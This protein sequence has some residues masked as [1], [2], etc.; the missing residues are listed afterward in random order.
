MHNFKELNI[1]E[2][3]LQPAN[4]V[5]KLHKKFPAG[6]RFGPVSRINRCPISIPSNIAEVSFIKSFED[7]FRFLE[8]APGSGFEPETQV[9]AEKCGYVSRQ[10][11]KE[12]TERI[13][14]I[15]KMTSVLKKKYKVQ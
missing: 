8:M 14:E 11:C 15:Q 10:A 3:S 12:I 1:W 2:D 13:T 4:N 7:F 9:I 5:Y 6:G